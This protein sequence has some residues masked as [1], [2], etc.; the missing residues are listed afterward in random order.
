MKIEQLNKNMERAEF[1][2]L[3]CRFAECLPK[4]AERSAIGD[5]KLAQAL[6]IAYTEFRPVLERRLLINIAKREIKYWADIFDKGLKLREER[7]L[8]SD[9]IAMNF[10]RIEADRWQDKLNSLTKE[11]H[12]KRTTK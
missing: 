1:T 9:N 5:K 12:D 3:F 11:Q 6:A 4:S 8:E 10:A 2:Q 7:K